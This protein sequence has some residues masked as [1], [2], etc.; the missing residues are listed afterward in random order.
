MIDIAL[1]EEHIVKFKSELSISSV[2]D[3]VQRRI[4]FGE[5]LILSK[6][7]YHSLR[8]KVGN[9]FNVHPN[10]VLVVGSAK[11]GFSIA[12]QKQY[13]T[14]G[15]TSDIDV[16]IVNSALFDT[17]WRSVYHMWKE[18]VL[19]NT[20]TDFKKYLFQGWIRPDKMPVSNKYSITDDW[21]EFFRQ[22]TSTNEFGPYKINGAIYKDWYFLEGYQNFAVQ[23]CKEQLS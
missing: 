9:E 17:F 1:I 13:R 7:D 8:L 23:N 16:V 18:K 6:N 5:C 12:P 15:E 19:W 22:L 3:I 2:S 11:L 20:E 10:D 21:W 14:F 4:I